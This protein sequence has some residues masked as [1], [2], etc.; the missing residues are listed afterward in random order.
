MSSRRSKLCHLQKMT[1][2]DYNVI[3]AALNF[4]LKVD[5]S[6]FQDDKG[7]IKHHTTLAVLILELWKMKKN[8]LN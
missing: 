5:L 7:V 6:V 3:F 8:I 1:L 2:S 4:S